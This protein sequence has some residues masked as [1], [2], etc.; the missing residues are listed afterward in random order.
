M[1]SWSH[2]VLE[3][4]GSWS[5]GVELWDPGVMEPSDL[6]PGE[7]ELSYGILESWSRVIGVLKSWS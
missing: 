3:S 4:L 6:G 1:G 2:G 5:H 7:M